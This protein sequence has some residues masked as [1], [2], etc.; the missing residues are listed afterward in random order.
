MA[1]FCS[2]EI[3]QAPTCLV[4]LLLDALLSN[5]KPIAGKRHTLLKSE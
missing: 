4:T 1:P 3:L 5:A 2:L